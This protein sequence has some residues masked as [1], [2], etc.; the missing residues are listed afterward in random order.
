MRL[1]VTPNLICRCGHN[2]LNHKHAMPEATY[3]GYPGCKCDTFIG[4]PTPL[5]VLNAIKVL[6]AYVRETRYKSVTIGP[7]GGAYFEI[8]TID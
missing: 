5:D 6:G 8:R 7:E 2:L 4:K 1:E 3:C